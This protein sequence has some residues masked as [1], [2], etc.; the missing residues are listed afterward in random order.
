MIDSHCHLTYEPLANQLNSVLAR[1]TAAGVERMITIGTDIT[2]A[3]RAIKLCES[4]L[5]IRC[6]IGIHPHHSAKAHD[7][8]VKWLRSLQQSETVLALGEMGLDY[9][10]D[11]SPRDRQ[12]QIFTQQLELASELNRPIVIHCR[13]ATDD[14][15]AILKDFP[16]IRALFH[17]FTGSPAEA[18][19]ILDQGYLLGF[20]GIVT[21]KKSDD[22]R[23]VA[24]F[25]PS[26]RLVVETDAPY[27]SPDPVRKQKINE[28]SFVIHTAR[29]VAELRNISLEQLDALTTQNVS[30]HFGWP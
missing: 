24:K 12:K 4:N 2:D 10:Y 20:T 23:E 22:L 16:T 8:D 19:Q 17:C 7:D 6:A 5:N 21:Y 25:T 28:P 15:L 13:E 14:C 18:R 3:Q 26:D 11:F 30:R 29:L 1:A 27:L 9:H